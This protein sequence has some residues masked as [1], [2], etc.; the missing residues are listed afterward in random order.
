MTY[1]GTN[2]QV[3]LVLCTPPYG[4]GWWSKPIDKENTLPSLLGSKRA[5][6]VSAHAGQIHDY[7]DY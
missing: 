2:K 4:R 5:S 7:L 3:I 1:H 6:L